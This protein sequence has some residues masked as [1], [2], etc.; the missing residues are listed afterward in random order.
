MSNTANRFRTAALGGF[1]K[2]D[3]LDYITTTNKEHLEQAAELTKQA[4]QARQEREELAEKLTAAE[5]ARDKSAAECERLGAALAQRSAALERAEKELAALK[6]E[7]EKTGARLAELEEKLP[8][9]ESGAAAYAVLKERLATIEL[10]A[11]RKAQET[12]EQA[13][14]DAAALRG[15]V[16]GW[17]N[18]VQSGYQR[19]RA[20]ISATVAHLAGE[21]ERGRA[22]LEEVGSSFRQHDEALESLLQSEHRA[23]GVPAPAPLPLEESGEGA[24][25][26]EPAEIEEEGKA[27]V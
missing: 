24:E 25:S 17:L 22:A 1:H 10:E 15:D 7:R 5:E 4:Q 20:D 21:L 26:L 18:R 19:L 9:L 14:I 27:D 13:E 6:A 12:V 2:Q 3:V 11:H 23:L 8:G 16:E